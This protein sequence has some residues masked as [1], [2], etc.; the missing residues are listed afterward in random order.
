MDIDV[1]AAGSFMAT[2]ARAL[3]RRRFELLV[4]GG[5]P[6]AV[7]GALD[8][9]CNPDGGYGWGLE[10]DLRCR[11]SQPGGALHAFEVLAEVA[12]ATSPRAA[13]LCDWLASI[14]MPDGGMPFA[15]PIGDPAGCA[16]FWIDAEHETSSLHITTAVAAQAHRVARADPAVAGH[17]WLAAAT[18]YCLAAIEALDV[19]H[20]HELSY[21]LQ[22]LDVIA[23]SD[24]SASSLLD[25]LAT[26][27]PPDG[28]LH[29]EGGTEHEALRVLDYAPRPGT[30]L[31]VL[32]PQDVVDADL[33][34]LAGQ[35]QTDGG[36]IVDY[37]SFSPVA[38]LEWRGY[39]TVRA[40]SI[41][42]R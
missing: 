38:A 17:P 6:D 15:L 27:I 25:K 19:P 8:A 16:P 11:E 14:S 13:E 42:R 18:E 22:F 35:Q 29:V 32:L 23:T 37:N 12:P 39:V 28:S 9:Y 4:D 40:V 36:W 30:P 5:P 34:R 31:R 21:A 10:P 24:A 1:E 26:L 7:L 3:D 41:S 20:A 2:H 33:E